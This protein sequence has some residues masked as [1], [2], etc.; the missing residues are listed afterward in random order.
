VS[1]VIRP[2]DSQ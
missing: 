1:Q 2:C